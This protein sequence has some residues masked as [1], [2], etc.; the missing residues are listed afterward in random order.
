MKGSTAEH[1]WARMRAR[2]GWCTMGTAGRLRSRPRAT[3]ASHMS[4]VNGLPAHILLVHFIVV[5]APLT[6]ILA[7]VCAVWPAA[8]RRLVWLVLALAVV[9]VALTPLTVE[10]GEWLRGHIGGSDA[11]E[12]HEEL[13]ESML[14]FAIGLLVGAILLVAVHLR[15]RQEKPLKTVIAV[16]VAVVVLAISAATM[17]Q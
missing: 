6:A 3:K 16:V 14:Y 7:A 15:R 17:A 9:I 11:L 5:L 12:R 13:G 8:L 1:C 10:A 4:T 2:V